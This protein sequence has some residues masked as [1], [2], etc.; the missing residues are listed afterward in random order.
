LLFFICSIIRNNAPIFSIISA[1]LNIGKSNI[2]ILIKSLTPHKNIL[3]T[4]FPIVPAINK[5]A[6]CRLICFCLNN[7]KNI[8]IP[9]LLIPMIMKKGIGSD[10]DIH[11]FNI[12]LISVESLKYSKV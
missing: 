4:K 1:I 8:H 9:M 6:I 7:R 10:R 12:G 3:S 11:T 5:P 2:P